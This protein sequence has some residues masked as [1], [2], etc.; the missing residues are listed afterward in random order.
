MSVS[1]PRCLAFLIASTSAVFA[2]TI[3]N[4]SPDVN[5]RFSSDF[6]TTAPVANASPLFLAAGYDLSS[7]GWWDQ[8]GDQQRV[9]HST[10]IAP[11]FSANAAHYPFAVGNTV[12]F[13][14]TDGTLQTNTVAFRST[15]WGDA[16]VTR[17]A[18]AFTESDK[19]SVIRILDVSSMNY[20]GQSAFIVGSQGIAVPGGA[21]IGTEFA[22]ARVAAVTTGSTSSV[23]FVNHSMDNSLSF[24]ML[25]SGDS[26][27]PT[28]ITYKGEIT[29]IGTVQSASAGGPTYAPTTPTAVAAN[30][31]LSAYGYALRYT[32]YDV[33]SDTA[34]TANAWTGG[35]GSADFFANGN[36]SSGSAPGN[37]PVVFDAG[38]NGGQS[39]VTLNAAQ[40]VRGMLFRANAGAT[41]FT[42]NG[43]GTLTV[44]STGIRNED[45]KTQTFDVAM[46]LSSAQNWEAA[47]GNLVFNGNLANGG[48]LLVVQGAK[49]TTIQGAISGTGGLAK[50]E[51]GTLV[52]GG[53]NT[54][55][56]K[57]FLH[58]GVLRAGADNVFSTASAVA[59]DTAN[60]GAVLDVDGRS[61]GLGN[62]QSDLDGKGRVT[63][64][65]GVLTTGSQNT[66]ATYAGTFEG[67]GRVVKQGTGTWTLTGSN[68]AYTGS[69]EAANGIIQVGASR[70]LGGGQNLIGVTGRVQTATSLDVHGALTFSATQTGATTLTAGYGGNALA[71]LGADTLVTYHDAITLD[72]QGTGTGELKYNFRT[73]G[74][75][76]Q[77]LVI[78]GNVT[79]AGSNTGIVGFES[80]TPGSTQNVID[81]QG[82][83]AD[84]VGG[85]QIR[86]NVTGAG[87]TI[88]SHT[89]GNGYTGGT[90]IYAGTTLLVNNDSGSGTGSGAVDVRSGAT[91]GGTGLIAP[92]G[93]NGISV[94]SGATIAPGE[95]GLGVLE[96][97]LA[98]TTGKSVFQP[99][100]VFAFDLNAP[101]LNDTL[102]F[103]G[104]SASDVTFNAN[105]VN[106]TNLGG[107][108]PGSYTLFTFDAANAYTG[109]LAVGSGLG[110]YEGSFIYNSQS[111]VLNVVPEPHTGLLVALGLLTVAFTRKRPQS[112]RFSQALSKKYNT[113]LL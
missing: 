22:T 43:S 21:D 50:D 2:I 95:G 73:A 1:L 87:T 24:K 9:K 71:A 104:M 18:S 102:A 33:P 26:G 29:L 74:G 55:S 8:P 93:N 28:M 64:D 63:L 36:W 62:L 88:L 103:T 47:E 94:A 49:D 78:A 70:A 84:G 109:T 110:A 72:R 107:L 19:V 35:A 42:L 76:A 89:A 105:V 108:A 14:A 41:G 112:P 67:P 77:R 52:L 61:V 46:A 60:P 99:G 45:T 101:A 59:F 100:A 51:S 98:S 69:L 10:L 66:A 48:N 31:M 57:T 56:G 85:P 92:G 6:R 23:T 58:N 5:Y 40:S 80:W 7:I 82:R 97:N 38:A 37:L 65:G 12:R 39:T 79:S 86:F 17:Y 20:T 75:G 3:N 83:I 90:N 34:N 111:I 53:A 25:Q 13:L 44:G 54:Y 15:A 32:I 81:F 30:A 91:L 68:S 16:S 4:E 113:P 11:L 106:F 96:I 27:S